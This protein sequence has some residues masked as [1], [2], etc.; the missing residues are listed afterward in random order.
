MGSSARPAYGKRWL[1]AALVTSAAALALIVAWPAILAWWLP[2]AGGAAAYEHTGTF[3]DSFAPVIGVLTALALGATAASTYMQV[4]E[5]REAREHADKQAAA[6]DR[7]N[8]LAEE[9]NKLAERQAAAQDRAIELAED[10]SYLE[11]S[12]QLVEIWRQQHELDVAATEMIEEMLNYGAVASQGPAPTMEQPWA[13]WF[14]FWK[15]APGERATKHGDFNTP[16]LRSMAAHRMALQLR[17]DELSKD[18]PV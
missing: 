9:A 1:V 5:M 17:A 8:D 7:A 13:T 15:A 10:A 3:G 4:I 16:L 6:Q 12:A 14:A 18:A 11:R 2:L